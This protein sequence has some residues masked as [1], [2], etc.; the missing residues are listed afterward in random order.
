MKK[1]LLWVGLG[2]VVVAA[3]AFAGWYFF[4]KSDPA[5][6]AAIKDTPLQTQ[7]PADPSSGG[8]TGSSSALDG[9]YT[10]KP[11]NTDNFVGYRV[12][13]KLVANVVESTATGRTNNVTGTMTIAGTTVNDVTVTGDLRDLTSG[14]SFR[15]QR[16]HSSGIESDR[17]PEAKFVLTT[18]ITLPKTPAAGETLSVDGTGDFTLHGVTKRVTITFQGRWDGKDIQVVGNLPIAFSDYNITAPTAPVVASV[19]DHGEMELQLF[20]KKS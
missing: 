11:G 13:E 10:V 20:F 9:T 19:D 12:T 15:D 14:Q 8:E 1:I 3:V 5:P 17:F 6:R 16:I 4:L 7:A 2:I 18:P